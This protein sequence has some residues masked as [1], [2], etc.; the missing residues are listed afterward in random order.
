[1]VGRKL[2]KDERVEH[3]IFTGERHISRTDVITGKRRKKL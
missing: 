1:M 2:R 3:N